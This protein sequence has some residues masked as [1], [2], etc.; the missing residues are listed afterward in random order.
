MAVFR[1]SNRCIRVT[2][3]GA[4]A[5][6]FRRRGTAIK[7]FQES[8]ALVTDGVYRFTRNPMYL[9]MVIGLTGVACMLGTV[10]PLLVIPIF[11]WVI[12]TR[13]IRVEEGMLAERFGDEYVQYQARVRRWL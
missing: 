13:F 6:L 2:R 4:C 12:R 9:G 10:T 11:I 1:S 8:S 3:P 7:P 5:M